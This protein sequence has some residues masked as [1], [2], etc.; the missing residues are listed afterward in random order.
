MTALAENGSLILLLYVLTAIGLSSLCI[1]AAAGVIGCRLL[2]PILER[3]I[4][5][6]DKRNEL[7]LTDEDLDNMKI[8]MDDLI[9]TIAKFN[10]L[11]GPTEAQYALLK[12]SLDFAS[13][14]VNG[15]IYSN[16][17]DL[18]AAHDHN[19]ETDEEDEDD[20]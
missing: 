9:D 17:F 15:V 19:E 12:S 5:V 3:E 10:G 18:C 1:V 20:E 8:V 7:G 14:V 6:E 4:N 13:F 16:G 11:D 2:S